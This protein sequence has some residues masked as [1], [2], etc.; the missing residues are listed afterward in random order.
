MSAKALTAADAANQIES[1]NNNVRRA[2]STWDDCDVAALVD[3]N[4]NVGPATS[5]GDVVEIHPLDAVEYVLVKVDL[6]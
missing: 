1:A 5:L 2:V 6:R 3:A 4:G